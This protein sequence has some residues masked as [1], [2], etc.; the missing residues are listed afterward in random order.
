MA[1]GDLSI[2]EQELREAFRRSGLWRRGYDFKRAIE[3]SSVLISLRGFVRARRDKEQQQDGKP[4]P[5]Q[6]ALI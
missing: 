5:M 4:A 3:T 6:R 2:T 1:Q